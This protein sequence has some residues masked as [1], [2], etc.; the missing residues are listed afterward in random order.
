MTPPL[1][2]LNNTASEQR[3]L[4]Q[5]QPGKL[6]TLVEMCPSKVRIARH[7]GEFGKIFRCI[8]G[9]TLPCDEDKDLV[10]IRHPKTGRAYAGIRYPYVFS[11]PKAPSYLLV[12][13]NIAG[14]YVCDS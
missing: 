4:K 1:S 7:F 8:H 5:N 14:I 3:G 13:T 11:S 2:V 9:T 12:V 10:T 6:F